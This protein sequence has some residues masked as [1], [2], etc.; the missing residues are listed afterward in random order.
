M[1]VA[2]IVGIGYIFLNLLKAPMRDWAMFVSGIAFGVALLLMAD[3]KF[4]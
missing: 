2:I 4:W 3:T 1:I